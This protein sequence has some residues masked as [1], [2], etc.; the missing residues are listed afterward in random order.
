MALILSAQIFGFGSYFGPD[1]RGPNDID[2]LII[3]QS[4]SEKSISFA[5]QCKS[6]LTAN[7]SGTHVTILSEP[8]ERE[9]GFKAK[10]CAR[11]LGSVSSD[12]FA[13]EADEISVSIRDQRRV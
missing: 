9:L 4:T 6:Y 10:C 7:V 11:F 2:I 8:E 12:N 5:L 3:H 1:A 13:S